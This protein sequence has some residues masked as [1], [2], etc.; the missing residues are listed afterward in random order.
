MQGKDKKYLRG[1][2]NSLNPKFQI[3]KLGINDELLKSLNEYLEKYEIVKIN[4][5]NTCSDSKKEL[6]ETL[7]ANSFIVAGT[8]GHKIIVYK[9]SIE[10][11]KI[12][13]PK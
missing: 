1:I 8:I 9:E 6:V 5:L 10:N 11:K 4:I 3:G 13:F 2:A 12:I 7:E